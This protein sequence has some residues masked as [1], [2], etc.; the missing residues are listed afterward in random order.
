V[1]SL[2][3]RSAATWQQP[4]E[5]KELNDRLEKLGALEEL[6]RAVQEEMNSLTAARN[7]SGSSA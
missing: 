3:H 1:K 4:G 5:G 6:G 2:R 7:S